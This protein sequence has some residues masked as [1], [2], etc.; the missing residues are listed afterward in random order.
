MVG[1][2]AV[3]ILCTL[4]EGMS[5]STGCK[6]LCDWDAPSDDKKTT[7]QNYTTLSLSLALALSL[8]DIIKVIQFITSLVTSKLPV[9]AKIR[10]F[11][12]F[13]G[14]LLRKKICNTLQD[15]NPMWKRHLSCIDVQ[16]NM[17][18][19]FS[20]LKGFAIFKNITVEI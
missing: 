7:I 13:N 1:E 5:T 3:E 19:V 11:Y 2:N 15:I 16:C 8:S 17:K 14:Y 6:L 4:G 12:I 9:Q 20:G 18:L 10:N